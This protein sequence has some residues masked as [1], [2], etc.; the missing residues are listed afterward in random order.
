MQ[1]RR[2]AELGRG[3]SW[4]DAAMDLMPDI[5]E[6]LRNKKRQYHWNAR[7]HKFVKATLKEFKE[8]KKLRIIGESGK[9]LTAKQLEP[10]QM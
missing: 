5:S 10:G 9:R 6:E 1:V 4:A 2:A 8:R 3:G 7:K